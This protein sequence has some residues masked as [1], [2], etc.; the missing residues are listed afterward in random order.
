MKILRKEYCCSSLVDA[1]KTSRTQVEENSGKYVVQTVS[2]KKR[3]GSA[4][5]ASFVGC[6]IYKFLY[7]I[8]TRIIPRVLGMKVSLKRKTPG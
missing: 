7:V 1:E 2:E 3:S 6:L 8:H 5:H 4:S